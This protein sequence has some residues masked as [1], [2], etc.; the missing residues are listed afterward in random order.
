MALLLK[1]EVREDIRAANITAS[2]KPRRPEKVQKDGTVRVTN[3]ANN[4]MPYC[5]MIIGGD[6]Q[7][8]GFQDLWIRSDQ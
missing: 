6:M 4:D 2:I 8:P 7:R 5:A 1:T 3:Q